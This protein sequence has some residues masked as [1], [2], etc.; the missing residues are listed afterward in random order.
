M[1][2]A[3]PILLLAVSHAFVVVFVVVAL[4][5]LYLPCTGLPTSEIAMIWICG[6]PLWNEKRS[7][8]N[9]KFFGSGLAPG[10]CCSYRCRQRDVAIV[11]TEGTGLSRRALA[12]GRR[13]SRRAGARPGA[14][15]SPP[16]SPCSPWW[17][18]AS[19]KQ[20]T[21]RHGLS[22]M[23]LDRSSWYGGRFRSVTK[24]V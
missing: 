3:L 24:E 19:S 4:P 23:A 5:A 21:W 13:P 1:R 15:S 20:R 22:S 11:R 17:P 8:R 12:S 10:T 7:I 16:C 2:G 18:H 9:R 6:Q 14:G